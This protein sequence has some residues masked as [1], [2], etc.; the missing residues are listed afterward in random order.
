VFREILVAIDGSAM[1][2]RAL[3]TATGLAEALNSR[4]TIISVSPEVPPY[5]YRS[6]V[7]VEKLEHEAEAETDGILRDAVA[8]LPEKLPV[9]TVLKHG[10]PGERIVEQIRDGRHDLL[11][12]GSR[13]RGRL[14][15][16]IFGS[17]SAYV[18]Y[19]CRVAML[20]IQPDE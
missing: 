13:G 17:T 18:H 14:V 6:G 8:S 10:H 3:E 7:D 4:L 2:Q 11:V 1:A 9:T 19:H 20:V 15:S 12:M 5:A 16:N